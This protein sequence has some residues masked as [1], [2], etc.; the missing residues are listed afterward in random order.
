MSP[1]TCQL[2]QND[3]SCWHRD[4]FDERNQA[5]VVRDFVHQF[6]PDIIRWDLKRRGIST[7]CCP[8]LDKLI[9]M[10]RQT[11]DGWWSLNTPL[12]KVRTTC[13]HAQPSYIIDKDFRG[14]SILKEWHGDPQQ[15]CLSIGKI[16][17]DNLLFRMKGLDVPA[18]LC[19]AQ[20]QCW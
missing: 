12:Q 13:F 2:Q 5:P 15:V 6:L 18:D 20:F 14:Q 1:E 3:H 8:N 11:V 10:G 19:L 9:D 17:V 16:Q 4:S 7:F